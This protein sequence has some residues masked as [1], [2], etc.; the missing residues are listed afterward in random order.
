MMFSQKTSVQVVALDWWRTLSALLV[1]FWQANIVFGRSF[2]QK[3]EVLV[4]IGGCL[5]EPPKCPSGCAG[6]KELHILSLG[7]QAKYI[8]CKNQ[9]SSFK[10]FVC[11]WQDFFVNRG[12]VSNETI[13]LQ[14]SKFSRWSSEFEISCECDHMKTRSSSMNAEQLGGFISVHAFGNW[15]FKRQEIVIISSAWISL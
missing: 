2:Q 7:P 8:Y 3:L 13:L 14:G 15:L 4:M 11:S 5:Y 12:T 9:K 10:C 1:Q 6:V